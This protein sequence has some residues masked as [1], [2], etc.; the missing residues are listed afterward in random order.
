MSLPHLLLVDDSEAILAFERAAL[1]SHY[2]ISTA[3]T[4][5]E[6]LEK[7]RQVRP[8]AVL[9][10]L[11]MPHMD[12]DEVLQRMK[13]DR[14]LKD[15]PVIVVS[16][17]R[18]REQDCLRA[19]ADGFM[20]KPIRAVELAA[21]VGDVLERAAARAREGSL[22]VLFVSVGTYL[23]GL[24]LE[25]VDSA[26]QLPLTQPLPAGPTYLSE[27]AEIYGEPLCVMDLSLRLGVAPGVSRLEQKLVVI[28]QEGQKLALK[29]DRVE[30]P[31]EMPR[32]SVVPRS[33]LGG[34]GEG[35]LGELLV[36]MVHGPRGA[37]PVLDPRALL[38]RSL[39]NKLPEL[40]ARVPAA[41]A[42]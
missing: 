30:D 21:L 26:V 32:E 42:T 20:A 6:A 39:W 27:Y 12:G 7:V 33:R 13:A 24:P 1:S 19:G 18:Q 25:A 38:K 29:V 5:A 16:S 4:G 10:D 31:E 34:T 36:A 15:I 17:E 9:L 22:A 14:E 37:V 23:F 8:A 40:L 28:R 11:S 2:A 35:P 41:A 3:T